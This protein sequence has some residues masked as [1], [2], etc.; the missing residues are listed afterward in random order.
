ECLDDA[1]AS[2]RLDPVLA[3]LLPDELFVVAVEEAGGWYVSPVETLAAY[4]RDVVEQVDERHLTAM[5]LVEPVALDLGAS[6]DGELA[7]PY[8][9]H[10]FTFEVEEGT[11]YLATVEGDGDLPM[12]A[13]VHPVGAEVW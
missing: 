12:E 7:S 13:A 1:L 11:P 4:L 9:R 6:H 3:E 5:G 10:A 2:N 8:E